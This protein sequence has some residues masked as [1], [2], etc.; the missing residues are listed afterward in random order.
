[1]AWLPDQCC[2]MKEHALASSTSFSGCFKGFPRYVSVLHR[3]RYFE[4]VLSPVACFGA[5]HRPI[6]KD[7][8]AKLDVE[9]R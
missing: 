8:F 4:K 9:Y 2:G 6:H 1:M 7:D 3:L 5:S